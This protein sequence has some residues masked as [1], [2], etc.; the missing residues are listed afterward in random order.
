[1]DQNPQETGQP[2]ECIRN[3][4]FHSVYR[5]YCHDDIRKNQC[6]LPAVTRSYWADCGI[7]SWHS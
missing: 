3:T 4:S 1:M 5:G 7:Y 6:S 2:I